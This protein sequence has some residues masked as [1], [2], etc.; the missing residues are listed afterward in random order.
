MRENSDV[1]SVTQQ[2]GGWVW[3]ISTEDPVRN[4]MRLVRQSSRALQTYEAALADAE[5]ALLDM[6]RNK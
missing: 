4:R 5:E 6:N 2:S 1:I 3:S